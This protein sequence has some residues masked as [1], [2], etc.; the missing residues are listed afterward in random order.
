MPGRAAR[1]ACG[2]LVEDLISPADKAALGGLA[3]GSRLAIDIG[4]YCGASAQAMLE[5]GAEAVLTLDTFEGSGWTGKWGEAL[6]EDWARLR[7]KPFGGRCNILRARSPGVASLFAD[8]IADLIFLDAAHD[9][10][11]VKADIE[12]WRPKLRPGGVLCGHD[13]DPL[14][15]ARMAEDME[16]FAAASHEDHAHMGV[17][18]GVIRAVIECCPGFQVIEGTTIWRAA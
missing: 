3:K 13:F 7:L 14:I 5:G 4:T 11:S 10:A 1:F 18:Y 12:A 8:G 15:D 2:R 17:H 16:A 6:A 9:Y